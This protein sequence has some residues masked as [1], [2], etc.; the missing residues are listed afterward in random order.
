LTVRVYVPVGVEVAVCTF[1]ADGP[2]TEMELGLNV[3]VAPDGNPV[4]DIV[5][6][7]L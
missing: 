6:V 1:I 5:S 4:T 3:A 2:E 7:A